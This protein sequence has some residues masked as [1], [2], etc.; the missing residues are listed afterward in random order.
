MLNNKETLQEAVEPYGLKG[1][2]DSK[3]IFLVMGDEEH[4][5]FV[6]DIKNG[7]FTTSVKV[8]D[9]IYKL[10]WG[11]NVLRERSDF[12]RVIKNQSS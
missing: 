9:D 6:V 5:D 8:T 11:I 3:D 10:Y 1:E 12:I 4:A 2:Y 7:G